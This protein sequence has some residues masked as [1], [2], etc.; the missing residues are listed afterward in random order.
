MAAAEEI[1]LEIVPEGDILRVRAGHQIIASAELEDRALV[2]LSE[3]A[4]RYAR[5][6]KLRF[7]DVARN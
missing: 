6:R 3:L 2:K 4:R 5:R 1:V 7:V